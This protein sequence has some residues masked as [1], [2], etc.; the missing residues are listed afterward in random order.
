MRNAPKVAQY[1][2]DHFGPEN[3][4][5]L[6]RGILSE[7]WHF[8]P[9]FK[10]YSAYCPNCEGSPFSLAGW[11]FPSLSHRSI[12]L[13]PKN[14]PAFLISDHSFHWRNHRAN[15][16]SIGLGEWVEY[17]RHRSP[18]NENNRA[19]PA[20]LIPAAEVDN[21][22]FLSSVIKTIIAS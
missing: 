4:L 2:S 5:H 11:L 8:R 17:L 3:R 9:F 18:Y 14:P 13:N 22:F 20:V 6:I 21:N 7:I 19:L 1:D 10:D 16:F 12:N 15:R